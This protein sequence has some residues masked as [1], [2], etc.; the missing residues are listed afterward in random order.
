MADAKIIKGTKIEPGDEK[1]LD[2]TKRGISMTGTPAVAEV[3]GQEIAMGYTQCPW[4]G[5]IGRSVID[6]SAYHW[7]TCGNCGQNFKA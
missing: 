7:Y 6:T 2:P 5:N 1:A 4:C 3:E